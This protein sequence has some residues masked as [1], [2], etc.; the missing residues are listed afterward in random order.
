MD[1][2]QLIDNYIKLRDKV[3]AINNEAKEKTAKLRVLM[4]RIETQLAQVLTAAGGKSLNT[5]AGTAFFKTA[6]SCTVGDWDKTFEWIVE[7]EA[8][9]FLEH[10][11]SKTAVEEFAQSTGGD[12]PPGVNYSTAKVVQIRRA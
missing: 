11:V 2:N 9:N 10:R 6:T 4:D 7:N 5:D 8:W 1:A 3:D 12:L